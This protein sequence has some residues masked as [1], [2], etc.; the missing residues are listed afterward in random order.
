MENNNKLSNGKAVF[1]DTVKPK[2][3][4]DILELVYKHQDT[5]YI[6]SMKINEKY[7]KEDLKETAESLK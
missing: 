2:S 7:S 4:H 3:I 5:E 6:M 1:I